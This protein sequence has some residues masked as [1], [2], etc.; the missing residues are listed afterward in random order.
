MKRSSNLNI[1][2]K[3]LTRITFFRHLLSTHSLYVQ[4]DMLKGSQSAN[5]LNTHIT[6]ASPFVISLSTE[7]MCHSHGAKEQ[8]PP[9]LYVEISKFKSIFEQWQCDEAIL[10]KEETRGDLWRISFN[11]Y[12][13]WV[14]V[15]FVTIPIQVI[16]TSLCMCQ[17]TAVFHSL[18]SCLCTGSPKHQ[19]ITNQFPYISL[20]SHLILSQCWWELEHGSLYTGI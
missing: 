3:N 13:S 20:Y 1:K 7:D 12:Y 17:I 15:L 2:Y 10:A 19:H 16:K 9:L 14:G 18:F 8:M 6:H 5:T 4:Q 11:L